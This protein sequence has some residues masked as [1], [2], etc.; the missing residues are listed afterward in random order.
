M[1][2][3]FHGNTEKFLEI[4]N[5]YDWDFCQIQYN[6][7]DEHSQAGVAGLKAAH[8]KGIPVIIMEPLRGGKLVNML[9]EASKK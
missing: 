7:L 8:K 3:S 2:F 5:A 6:Y 9:P 4:L 1:G